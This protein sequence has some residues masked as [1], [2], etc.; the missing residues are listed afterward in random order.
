MLIELK[1]VF[2]GLY[3]ANK[4]SVVVSSANLSRKSF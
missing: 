1:V 4:A 3:T 2:Y